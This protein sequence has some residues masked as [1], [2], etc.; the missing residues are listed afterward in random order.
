MAILDL[1]GKKIFVEVEGEGP[2]LLFVHGLGGTTTFFEAQARALAAKHR[3]VRFDLE[4]HGRSELSGGELTIASF[5]A[6]AIALLDALGI[7]SADVVGH[8]LGT[9]PVQHLAA[10]HRDRVGKVVLLGPIREQPPAG[11]EATRARAATVREKG[12]EAVASAIA[13]AATSPT[14]QRERP[15]L[16]GFVRELLLGQSPEGYAR[17]CEALA[18]AKAVD[19]SGV[20]TPVL[21]L[22]GDD[23]KVSSNETVVAMAKELA[24][25]RTGVLEGCG[26]WTAIEAAARVT[27]ALTEFF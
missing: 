12:M 7:R 4:G 17:A 6:D 25:A 5:A 23:D 14:V 24:H 16:L 27:A 9:I 13:N 11:K 8:S 19:L 22:R 10:H 1:K 2:A 21:L 15:E 18:Q 20:E 26:H 3:V